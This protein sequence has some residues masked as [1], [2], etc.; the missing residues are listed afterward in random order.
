MK[1]R[2][3]R[4]HAGKGEKNAS[5]VFRYIKANPIADIRKMAEAWGMSFN[6]AAAVIQRLAN[7]KSW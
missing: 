1:K 6:T 2:G 4:R 7:A 5:R 3:F